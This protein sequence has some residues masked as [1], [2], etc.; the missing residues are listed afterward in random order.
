MD[1]PADP[2]TT[3]MRQLEHANRRMEAILNSSGD[4]ILL[5]DVRHGIQ[6]VNF[7]FCELFRCDQE[8]YFG[9]SLDS[10]LAPAYVS[11]LRIILSQTVDSQLRSIP[12]EVQAM[13]S[14]AS[15]FDAEVGLAPVRRLPDEEQLIVCTIRDISARKMAEQARHQAE[16]MYRGLF[17]QSNDAVILLDRNGKHLRVNQRAADMFGYSV[18]DLLEMDVTTVSAEVPSSLRVIDLLMEVG[19]VPPYLRWF[20]R[21]SGEVFPV[22]VNVELIRDSRGNFSH[23]QS[24]MR[25]LSSHYR[26]QQEVKDKDDELQRFFTSSLDL[27][28]IADITNGLFVRANVMWQEAMGYAT[29]DIIGTPLLDLVHPDDVQAT[30]DVMQILVQGNIVRDFVNRCCCADGT[31]RHLEWRAVLHG[32]LIYAAARDITEH[33]ATIQALHESE[34][35]LKATLAAIPDMVFRNALD[36]TY[37]DYHGPIGPGLAI[38]PDVFIDRKPEDVLPDEVSELAYKSIQEAQRRQGVYQHEYSLSLPDGIHDFEARSVP[39]NNHE[40][41]TIVRD[42]TE[43]NQMDRDLRES[44]TRFR[45]IA[46]NTN[47]IFYVRSPDRSLL[48]VSPA[49]ETIFGRSCQSLYDSPFSYKENIHSEDLRLLSDTD[50]LM[51]RLARGS[52]TVEYRIVRPDGELRWVSERTFPVNDANGNMVR[53]VGIVEDVTERKHYEQTLN[54]ML[55]KEREVGE[56]KSR[57]VSMASHEFRTPLA[58]ILVTTETLKNYRDRLDGTQIDYRLGKILRQVKYMQQVMDN[59]LHIASAQAGKI[60]FNATLEDIDI[61]CQDIIEEYHSRPDYE[62]RIRYRCNHKPA[63]A[64]VDSRLLRQILSN[65]LSNALKYSSSKAPVDLDL[66]YG[67]HRITIRVRDYGIGIPAEELASIDQPFHR[68]RNVGTISGTGLGL[69]IVK[70]AAEAHGGEIRF[71]SEVDVGTSCTIILPNRQHGEL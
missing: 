34:Q 70:Q 16:Q 27:L 33:L 38:S 40:V 56:L 67:E 18:D 63:F 51:R 65:L 13:R 47:Q 9:K 55:D 23:I 35:R 4:A 48:Y 10:L 22:E 20:R 46:E 41:L 58:T 43:Q 54:K 8:E 26:M 15:L 39:I 50:E 68:A 52:S 71:A 69:S 44:E 28:S 5:I 62:G 24:I 31:Y 42:V 37:L 45:Q 53:Y 29:E 32:N 19:H 49:Y 17:E 12:T 3:R 57:F 7:A 21:S 64:E 11:H 59:L 14:D 60:E 25:D 1:P 2:S 36:G 66:S 61:I 6:Q 30:Q